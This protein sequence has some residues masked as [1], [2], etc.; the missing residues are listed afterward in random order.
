M[1]KVNFYF[2]TLKTNSL[3][4]YGLDFMDQPQLL[5]LYLPIKN[6]TV[7]IKNTTNYPSNNPIT[8]NQNT[9]TNINSPFKT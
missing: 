2:S 9:N 8:I 7:N 3:N 4:N 5:N 1:R 6:T